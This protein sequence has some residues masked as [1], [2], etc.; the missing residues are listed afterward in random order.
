VDF[1]GGH[2]LLCLLQSLASLFQLLA[3]AIEF[4]G[5]GGDAVFGQP[6]QVFHCFVLLARGFEFFARL[7]KDHLGDGAF[8]EQELLAFEGLLR[9][10]V[11][12]AHALGLGARPRSFQAGRDQRAFQGTDPCLHALHIGLRG[13]ASCFQTLVVDASQQLALEDL[14]ARLNHVLFEEPFDGGR[15]GNH[16]PGANSAG[17]GHFGRQHHRGGWGRGG[18]ARGNPVLVEPR[19]GP[20]GDSRY[21][22]HDR[23]QPFALPHEAR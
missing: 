17:Q 10:L 4:F 22:Q 8:L 20:C 13:L 7:F 2:P 6:R 12:V 14:L 1:G 21:P 23:P 9:P 15:Y 18:N 3:R 5:E 16:V 19:G 11:V